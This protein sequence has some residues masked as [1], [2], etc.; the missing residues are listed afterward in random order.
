MYHKHT[1][2]MNKRY[3][4]YS[5]YLIKCQINLQSRLC[6]VF[7][8]SKRGIWIDDLHHFKYSPWF[9]SIVEQLLQFSFFPSVYETVNK[10]CVQV[11]SIAE[12]RVCKNWK[13]NDY[14]YWRTIIL[15]ISFQLS[16]SQRN[17]SSKDVRNGL[18]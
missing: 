4:A 9:G 13:T 12:K 17:V 10:T 15:K 7:L 11:V 8:T 18:S 6:H 14:H 3:Y 16:C 1:I 5:K 2:D